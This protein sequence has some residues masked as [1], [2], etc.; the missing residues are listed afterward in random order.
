MGKGEADVR[1]G[2][3]GRMTREKITPSA[4][5]NDTSAE[6]GQSPQGAPWWAGGE[7]PP[8]F[9]LGSLH[10]F[11]LRN[12]RLDVALALILLMVVI[13]CR[14]AAFPAS[15][16]DQDEAYLGLAV[17]DFDPA[18]NRPHPPWFPLWV[19]IGKTVAPISTDPA[20]GLRVS[21]AVAGVWTLFP[22]AALLAIW[23]RRHLAVAGAVLYLFLPGPWFLAGRA[24]SDTPAVLLLILTAAW[25]LRRRPDRIDLAAGSVAAGLGLLVRPQL[26][27]GIIGLGLWRLL[28]VRGPGHRWLVAGPLAGVVV[29]GALGTVFAA[30]GLAPLAT[31]LG[32]HARYHLSGLAETDHGFAA[33]GVARCVIRP[34]TAGLW[35]ALAVIG[36][37]VWARHRRSVG[38]PWPLLLC[39]LGPLVVTSQLL[40]NPTLPRYALPLLALSIG[41]VVIGLATVLRRWTFPAVAL[42]ATV[43]AV[44]GL[45]QT[46][47]Y[48]TIESPPVTALRIANDVVDR[49]DGTVAVDRTL[50]AFADYGR[51]AGWLRARVINDFQ[52][53]IGAVAPPPPE[54]TVAVFVR[55]RGGFVRSEASARAYRWP[56]GWVGRLESDRFM[57]VSVAIGPRV[58]GAASAW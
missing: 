21:A 38:R 29:A 39:L 49:S 43:L 25:W 5:S 34:E 30:G 53:E 35:L 55:G 28:T 57:D 15:I 8:P 32:A 51:A 24:Y 42:I 14:A 16:W 19:L 9:P 31:G 12:R 23:I 44:V 26:A 52:L 2:D 17:T 6:R 54:T 10:L 27:L 11:G 37:V 4:G 1:V 20:L 3:N 46:A 56:P 47:A 45:P 41:P 58:A 36:V 33:S 13:A 22:M 40:Q 48:R 7:T 50:I 18:A